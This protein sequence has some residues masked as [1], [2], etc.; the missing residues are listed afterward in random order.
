MKY[1]SN[2]ENERQPSARKPKAPISNSTAKIVKASRP[3]F[4]ETKSLTQ[5]LSESLNEKTKEHEPLKDISKQA[6]SNL[7]IETQ[8]K[9]MTK[10]QL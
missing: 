6:A 7:T 10:K 8:I 2:K 9:K 5:R 1:L 3:L 4:S